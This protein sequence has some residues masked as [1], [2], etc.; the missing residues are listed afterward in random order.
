MINGFK[1]YLVEEERTVYFT[2]GRM[3]PPTIGHG[4]LLDA[5]AAKAGRNPYRVYLSQSQNAKKDPIPFMDKIKHVR[6]MFPKHA[7]Q[8]VINKKAITP[9]YALTDLYNQGFRK[10]VM[11]AGSDRVN[12]YDIRLNKYNGVK[13]DHGFYNFEGGVKIISAGHRDADAEGAEG[14]SGTKQR[15]FASDNN[16]TMFSQGLPTSMSNKDARKLF[17]DVRKG[18]GLKEEKEFK[19]HIQLEPVSDLREA[20]IRDNIFELGEE[21][22]LNK[23]DGIVGKIQYLGSNYLIVE[24]KGERWRCWLDDVSKVNPNNEFKFKDFNIQATPEG[25]VTKLTENTDW[26]CGQC[27][28]EPCVCKSIEEAVWKKH[29][30]DGEIRIKHKGKEWRVRKNYDHND[31]HT[32]EYRIEY[33]TKNPYGGYDWEWHDT[34]RGKS[35]AKSRLPESTQPDWGTPESTKKAKQ[36][37]PGEATSWAQQAAIAIAKKKKGIKEEDSWK[38]EGHYTSDGKE[39]KGFQH[40]HNGMVMTGKTHTKDSQQLFHYKELPAS[41]RKKIETGLKETAQDPDIKDREGTQPKR[42]HT[43]LSKATKIARDRQFKKQAKMSDR[44]PAA[45]KPAPGDATAKTRPS[46]FTKFVDKMM[47]EHNYSSKEERIKAHKRLKAKHASA[48]DTRLAKMYDAK[49]KRDQE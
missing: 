12:E 23:K 1:Q 22:V 16:F 27:N 42:Y 15:G 13:G 34:V 36:M 45:Y 26:V 24:S 17:N 39:W 44:D 4:K 21:V 33:K 43:G 11:V 3:N 29:G 6:R 20:Y 5:L 28:S 38:S 35:H 31:R 32:G 9:F 30:N 40:Y 25:G 37:T 19:N 49:I 47:G 14:A 10:V 46:K 18:M 2:F 8:V 7:R 48:G 41:I